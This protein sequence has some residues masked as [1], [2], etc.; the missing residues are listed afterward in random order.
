M[1]TPTAGDLFANDSALDTAAK[2]LIELFGNTEQ[3]KLDQLLE[4][5][6][7]VD[8]LAAA[9]GTDRAE[10]EGLQATINASAVAFEREHPGALK[11]LLEAR[12]D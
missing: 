7:D 8:R 2:R 9:L 3:A 12:D 10:L 5:G 6:F 1:S 4:G 11:A